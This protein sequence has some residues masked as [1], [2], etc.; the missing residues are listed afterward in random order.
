MWDSRTTTNYSATPITKRKTF[1]SNRVIWYCICAPF[2]LL[3][4]LQ[5]LDNFELTCY[6]FQPI[7]KQVLHARPE[8]IHAHKWCD[9]TSGRIKSKSAWT[10]GKFEARAKLPLGTQLWPAIWMLPRDNKYGFWSA[11]G[12]IDIM[13]Y[14]GDKPHEI[15]GTIHYGGIYPN[16]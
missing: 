6:F 12:E 8:R 9:F 1:I 3:D 13:E 2:I 10:Y 14:R 7:R 11:N 5:S 15:S 4:L 16:M